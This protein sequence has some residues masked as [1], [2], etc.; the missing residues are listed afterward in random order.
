MT[1]FLQSAGIKII[2]PRN[3][4]SEKTRPQFCAG[5]KA[6]IDQAMFEPNP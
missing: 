2:F 5:E 4:T 1:Y 6:I 3:M